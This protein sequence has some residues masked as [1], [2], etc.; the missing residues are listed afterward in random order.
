MRTRRSWRGAA[1]AVGLASLLPLGTASASD[2]PDGRGDVTVIAV[3]DNGYNPYHYDF[4]ASRMP[5]ALDAD[6]SND[7]PLTTPPQDW[8]PGYSMLATPVALPITLPFGAT[9]SP[10][11]LAG[12]D[13]AVWDS[14]LPLNP[15]WIP[16]TKIVTAMTF[17]NGTR[18]LGSSG[19]HGAGT[20]S[21]SAGNV[22][23]SCPECVVVLLQYS[24][25]GG[26]ASA[27]RW[28]TRQPWIDVI[29]NSWGFSTGNRDN[30]T[31][32]SDP[33]HTKRSTERGQ[34]VFWSA[35]NGQENA[36]V[37]PV[38]TQY[39]S[40]K[41]PDWIIQVGAMSP[42][43][44]SYS[45]AGKTVDLAGIGSSYPASYGATTV[46]NGG[47]F[48]GTSNATPTLAGTY[49]RALYLARRALG[50]PSKTQAD[51]VIATGEPVVCG[52]VRP[53]CELG[54]GTLTSIELREALFAASVRTSGGMNVGGV[55]DV[56]AGDEIDMANEG[57][58]GWFVRQQRFRDDL[59]LSEFD[60]LWQPLI[61]D[62][63]YPT[64]PAGEAEW[65]IVDS[66]C[67]QQI[68]GDWALGAYVRDETTLPGDDTA[69]PVRSAYERICTEHP[70]LPPARNLP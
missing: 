57:H 47:T 21:V 27:V 18:I 24:S 64:R 19:S 33:I 53:S 31:W 2:S 9:N 16:G 6:P 52:A 32:Y 67:R 20:S 41:G 4:L 11:T 59:W 10:A 51:L 45:G 7:L 34:A 35:G 48:S 40:D 8:I 60:R 63:L 68:W 28:A 54:D 43:G 29:T 49:G 13:V 22:F 36:F 14:V 38:T 58:G 44:T 12:A 23:G 61:G 26:A 17:D 55:G 70:M 46:S 62:A 50:G 42:S 56:P 15:Y 69:W 25:Q 1:V 39:S 5:Q 66:Y 30:V 37:A 3:I 65:F